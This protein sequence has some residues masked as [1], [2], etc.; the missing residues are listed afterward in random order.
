M[1]TAGSIG[2]LTQAARTLGELPPALTAELAR[3][4]V[5]A[6]VFPDT[7]GAL[8]EAVTEALLGGRDVATDKRVAAALT[9]HTIAVSNVDSAVIRVL[10][11]RRVE[12][13][14]T[15]AAEIL[16]GW[17]AVVSE[18]NAAAEE[19]RETLG[20]LDV[21][22]DGARTLPPLALPVWGKARDTLARAD[23]V[24]NAWRQIAAITGNRYSSNRKYAP[25]I[26]ADLNAAE[27]DAANQATRTTASQLAAD[28]HALS[29][30]GF[31]EFAARIA[32]VTEDRDRAELDREQSEREAHKGSMW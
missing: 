20:R 5:H 16:A 9:R 18:A 1:T 23:V 11:S 32:R 14:R 21:T 29:L 24:P 15:H 27:L 22:P 13:F 8:G 2:L 31:E 12:A 28:G 19:A 26:L 4:N 17:A 7:H 10:D 30:A 6:P 25:L 3:L